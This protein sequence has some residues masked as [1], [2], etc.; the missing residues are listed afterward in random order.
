LAKKIFQSLKL[1]QANCQP[2]SIINHEPHKLVMTSLCYVS[3]GYCDTI[4]IIHW[5]I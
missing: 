3:C 2:K 1:Q 4:N 5:L